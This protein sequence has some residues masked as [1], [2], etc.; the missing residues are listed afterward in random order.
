MFFTASPEEGKH[1]LQLSEHAMLCI[2]SDRENFSPS[3]TPLPLAGFIKS[4][5]FTIFICPQGQEQ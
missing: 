1:H 5:T 3:G 4:L 2:A